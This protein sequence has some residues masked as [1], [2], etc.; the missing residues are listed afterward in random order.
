MTYRDL[1]PTTR[2]DYAELDDESKSC[3]LVID[4]HGTV[5]FKRNRVIDGAFD[6]GLLDLNGIWENMVTN[7]LP[8]EDMMQLYR[9]LGYSLSGFM[10]VFIDTGRYEK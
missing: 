8:M 1:P 5:R 6:A 4:E 9:M 7:N 2:E 10:E 3:P